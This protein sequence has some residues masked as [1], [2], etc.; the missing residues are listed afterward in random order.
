MN[1]KYLIYL[2]I[3]A[4]AAVGGVFVPCKNALAQQP[5]DYQYIYD[6]NGQLVRAIDS[7]GN[8]VTYEYDASGNLL[9]VK[10]STTVDLGPPVITG[11][12]PN[13]VNQ[14]DTVGIA[15]M[16]SN[17][18]QA[19]ITIDNTG[20]SIDSFNV[21]DDQINAVL[22]IAADASLG[23]STLTVTTPLG[24][25]STNITV[26]GPL[27]KV[28]EMSPSQGS[29]LG[30]TFVTLTGTNL[31]PDTT[32]T[33]GGSPAANVTFISSTSMTAMTTPSAAAGVNVDVVANNINGSFTLAGG[34]T[35]TFPFSIPGAVSIEIVNGSGSGILTMN[36]DT[37][38]GVDTV[39]TI[40]SSDPTVATVP[41]SMTILAG[42]SVVNIPIT[43]VGAGTAIITITINGISLS[44]ASFVSPPFTG[45]ID[46]VSVQVGTFVTPTTGV[47]FSP[48]V[49]SF[50]TPVGGITLAP[51]IGVDVTPVLLPTAL[52]SSGGVKSVTLTLA[53]PAPAGGLC[54]QITSSNSAVATVPVQVCINEGEQTVTFDITAISTGESLVIVNAGSEVFLINVL[55]NQPLVIPGSGLAAPV[56]AFICPTRGI[57][58]SPTV[59]AFITPTDTG[60]VLAPIVGV[61]VQ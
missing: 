11:A 49:G 40:V 2:I 6:S 48:A 18:L 27:P 38:V 36:L 56:G 8:V 52:L 30:G 37:P 23:I 14:E 41:A 45:N 46:L 61:E 34:F 3:V 53:N 47:T 29:A 13:I 1:K 21:T 32:I 59:G 50:V 25:A 7:D 12:V 60:P 16:G 57:T 4:L 39:I 58:L 15:I 28:T 42:V 33:I 31:T 17:L 19:D 55:V 35:Y 9:S 51:I 43:A 10:R 22:S 20:I 44:T 24:A 54:A 26:L 5:M